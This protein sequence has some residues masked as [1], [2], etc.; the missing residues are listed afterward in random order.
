MVVDSLNPFRQ[1][2][3]NLYAFCR[4]VLTSRRSFFRV[5]NVRFTQFLNSIKFDFFRCKILDTHSPLVFEYFRWFRPSNYRSGCD[6]DRIAS[7]LATCYRKWN[8]FE[9]R[10]RLTGS[11]DPCPLLVQYP[12][13]A[14]AKEATA[15]LNWF[16]IIICWD[17]V[18]LCYCYKLN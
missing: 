3:I 9:D 17:N 6:P 7:S 13:R 16:D 12:R 8:W 18:Y 4:V 1:N 11:I 14:E 2:H 10:D 15:S 5:Q